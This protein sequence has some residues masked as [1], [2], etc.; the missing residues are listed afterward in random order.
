MHWTIQTHWNSKY[1]SWKRL[2]ELKKS[3]I[4][5]NATLHLEE[6]R[7][8]RLDGQRLQKIM[9]C[10]EELILLEE[11]C[12]IFKPFDEVTTFFSGVNYATISSILP[13]IEALKVIFKKKLKEKFK[14]NFE[15]LEDENNNNKNNDDNDGKFNIFILIFIIIFIY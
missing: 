11:L 15:D 12:K 7:N 13:I 5:L 2:L 9:I 1:N 6:N 3:I 14:I 4:Y 10:D 8:D